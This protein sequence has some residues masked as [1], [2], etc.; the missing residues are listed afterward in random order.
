M[1]EGRR[2]PNRFSHLKMPPSIRTYI[3]EGFFKSAPREF[4][5][6]AELQNFRLL[7]LCKITRISETLFLTYPTKIIV[8]QPTLPFCSFS[9][10]PNA[11]PIRPP[12]LI[13]NYLP[14]SSAC[15]GDIFK[16]LSICIEVEGVTCAISQQN[17]DA[18]AFPYIPV[19]T[20]RILK[21]SP[22]KFVK[23]AH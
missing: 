22:N 6:F 19:K 8:Y 5:N 3:F 16:K 4:F 12:L 11:C 9:D 20:K 23:S 7:W 14:I 13:G 17:S 18:V 2:L 10:C 15:F 21:P 1:L